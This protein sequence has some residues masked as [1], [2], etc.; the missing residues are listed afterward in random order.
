[1]RRGEPPDR[2]LPL[3]CF[4]YRIASPSQQQSQCLTCRFVIVHPQHPHHRRPP[5][6]SHP[7]A[8]SGRDTSSVPPEV[9][10]RP[11]SNSSS[12][13]AYAIHRTRSRYP[14]LSTLAS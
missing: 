9:E 14:L 5:L 4:C 12:T 11:E 13:T 6:I 10:A 8:G 7:L 2:L 3:G 1:G